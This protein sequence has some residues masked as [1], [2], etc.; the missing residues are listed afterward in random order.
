MGR[1]HAVAVHKYAALFA[2]ESGGM[3]INNIGN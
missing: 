3:Y 1:E 2:L